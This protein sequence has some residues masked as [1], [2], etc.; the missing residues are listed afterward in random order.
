MTWRTAGLRTLRKL[1]RRP[2]SSR[3]SAISAS[4]SPSSPTRRS[5]SRASSS[6]PCADQPVR[7]LVLEEHAREHQDRLDGRQ[8]EHQPPVLAGRQSVVDQVGSENAGGYGQLVKADH[9]TAD[10]RRPGRRRGG[11]AARPACGLRWKRRCGGGPVALTSWTGALGQPR[12]GGGAAPRRRPAR[13]DTRRRGHCRD[14]VFRRRDRG[15]RGAPG[16]ALSLRPPESFLSGSPG[17]RPCTRRQEPFRSRFPHWRPAAAGRG[18]LPPD[19]AGCR[20]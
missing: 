13:R 8:A 9:G 10:P 16:L 6:R 5:T 19:Q 20:R 11:S 15:D 1:E 14:A 12:S 2:D 18:R 17:F 7:A 4:M 3:T